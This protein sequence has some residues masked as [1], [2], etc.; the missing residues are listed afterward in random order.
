MLK[1]S[2]QIKRV[3]GTDH[4]KRGH[5]RW[6]YV[7][8]NT[9][10][11]LDCSDYRTAKKKFTKGIFGEKTIAKFEAVL[12]FEIDTISEHIDTLKQ[13]IEKLELE[14]RSIRQKYENKKSKKKEVKRMYV[15]HWALEQNTTELPIVFLTKND[16]VDY[17]NKNLK[18][19]YLLVK[20]HQVDGIK[21]EARLSKTS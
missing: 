1:V 13:N 10:Y 18:G 2:T 4:C 8:G 21:K 16:A 6:G 5:S 7:R 11:C 12:D 19:E 14:K 9:R 17:A 3:R 20:H 15:K